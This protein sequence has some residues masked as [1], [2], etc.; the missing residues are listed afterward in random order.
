MT[1]DWCVHDQ[2]FGHQSTFSKV[3]TEL[4]WVSGSVTA[5]RFIDIAPE[6]DESHLHLHLLNVQLEKCEYDESI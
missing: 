3:V 1:L 5:V 4:G 2:C 6:H